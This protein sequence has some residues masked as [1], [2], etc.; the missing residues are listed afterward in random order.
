MSYGRID[1]NLLPPELQPGPAVR[2]AVILNVLIIACTVAY[3]ALDSVYGLAMLSYARQ[4]RTG[5]RDQV[6]KSKAVIADYDKL[7]NIKDKL[8][9]YGR[10]VGLASADYVDMPVL[11]D[12][13]SRILPDGVYIDRVTNDNGPGAI[14]KTVVV[15]GLRTSRRDP[16]LVL[17]TLRAFKHDALFTDCYMPTLNYEEMALQELMQRNQV[18]WTVAGPD[19]PENINA[20]EFSFEIRASVTRKLENLGLP[21]TADDSALFAGFAL[22]LPADTA[23]ALEQVPSAKPPAANEGQTG[24]PPAASATDTGAAGNPPKGVGVAEVH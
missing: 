12:R 11:L 7:V 8:E 22:A 24:P 21:I 4:E 23:G 18:K 14:G 19:V 3:I 5:L 2:Y 6:E 17:D 13:V 1:V 15:F 20:Q 10:L 16:Q 9:R